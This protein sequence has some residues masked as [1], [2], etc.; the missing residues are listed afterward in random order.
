MATCAHCGK[1]ASLWERVPPVEC[2]DGTVYHHRCYHQIAWHRY[3]PETKRH[4]EMTPAEREA[5]I[6]WLN[7]LH[8][9][10]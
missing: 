5:H 9:P 7:Q 4:Y 8:S 2:E 6:E 3:D 10:R 1:H